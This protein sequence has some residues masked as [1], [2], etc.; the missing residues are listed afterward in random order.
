VE[1][2]PPLSAYGVRRGF[3]LPLLIGQPLPDFCGKCVLPILGNMFSLFTPPGYVA[4]LSP[5]AASGP[6]LLG[7]MRD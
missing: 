7:V 2:R 1:L 3:P 4:G 5:Q 6:F